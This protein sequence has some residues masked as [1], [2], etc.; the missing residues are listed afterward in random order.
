M[1]SP[2]RAVGIRDTALR[3]VADRIAELGPGFHPAAIPIVAANV[4][5]ASMADQLLDDL[6]VPAALVVGHLRRL[7]DPTVPA[8][9]RGE[10]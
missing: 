1:T 7:C 9:E 10:W 2:D 5:M 6:Q 3:A 8:R 4:A